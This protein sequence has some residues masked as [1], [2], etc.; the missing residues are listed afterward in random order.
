MQVRSASPSMIAS[1]VQSSGRPGERR[2]AIAVD[3]H[4]RRTDAQT[5]QRAAHRQMGR[6]ENVQRID[7]FDVGPRDRPGDAPRRGS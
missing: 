6:F 3:L 2:T 1:N 5:D 7:F 4:V